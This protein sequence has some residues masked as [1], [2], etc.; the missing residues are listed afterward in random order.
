LKKPKKSNPLM[1]FEKVLW[2]QGVELVAGIDEVG[3]GALAGPVVACAVI[4]PKDIDFFKVKDSKKLTSGERETIYKKI[5]DKA[6]CIGIGKV[7]VKRINKINNIY[8]CGLE[9][10]R[11]AVYS[12]KIE[13]HHLLVDAREIPDIDLPQSR[14]N[15]GENINFSIAAASIIAKVYRDSLMRKHSYSYPEYQFDKHKGYAT[16]YHIEIL[17]KIGPCK[18]HRTCYEFVRGV[19]GEFSDDY[20]KFNNKIKEVKSE[21]DI[22]LLHKDLTKIEN[23]FSQAEWAR[24]RRKITNKRRSMRT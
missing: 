21:E 22:T 17:R 9:A 11:K 16:S 2:S 6:L 7:S 4:F 10:M 13:P 20:F 19:C 3:M 5:K 24:L 12:L 1:Y 14:F 8:R 23:E 18:I 15:N